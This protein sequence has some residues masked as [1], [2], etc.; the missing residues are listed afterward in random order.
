MSRVIMSRTKL[1]SRAEFI[2]VG[3]IALFSLVSACG[4]VPTKVSQTRYAKALEKAQPY[5]K[6][7]RTGIFSRAVTMQPESYAWQQLQRV[8][9][10]WE[11][12]DVMV[13]AEALATFLGKNQMQPLAARVRQALQAGRRDRPVKALPKLEAGA[14]KQGLLEAYRRLEQEGKS[15]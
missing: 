4:G 11:T 5:Y 12:L 9:K 3:V 7:L 15:D 10:H 1:G 2:V 8:A 6:T 14:I 13:S